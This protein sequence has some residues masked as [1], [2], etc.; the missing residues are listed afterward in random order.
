MKLVLAGGGIKVAAIAGALE[1]LSKEYDFEHI[2]GTSA[3]AILAFLYC[4]GTV[5]SK[6]IHIFKE[7]KLP[8]MEDIFTKFSGNYALVK[9]PELYNTLE[10]IF[11]M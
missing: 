10:N 4:C 11:K 1:K 3:G 7:I 5:I 6:I 9:N 8:E 2:I